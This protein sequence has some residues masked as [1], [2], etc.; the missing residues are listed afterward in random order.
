MFSFE[1]IVDAHAVLRI[2][3]DIQFTLHLAIPNGHILQNYVSRQDVDLHSV[4]RPSVRIPIRVLHTV[5]SA[6]VTSC[7]H[8]CLNVKKSLIC[9][10]LL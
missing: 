4:N 7:P 5:S 8:P 2:N 3:T 9:S 6:A 10:P 1:I